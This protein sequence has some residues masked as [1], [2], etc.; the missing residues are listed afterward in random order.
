MS[1]SAH[2]FDMEFDVIPF[3]GRALLL[4]PRTA[5]DD[6]LTLPRIGQYLQDTSS[7]EDVVATTAELM[8][9]GPLGALRGE[10]ARRSG[11]YRADDVVAR[12]FRLPI[13]FDEDGDGDWKS[14]LEASGLSRS[15]YVDA[16]LQARFQVAMYGF[17]P[18]FLYM[19]G[20]SDP[21]QC[22]RKST[23]ATGCEAGSVAVGGPWFGIYGLASP[24]GWNVIGRTPVQTA[25]LPELPPTP[26][27]IG[28]VIT[29]ESIEKAE[30]DK[31]GAEDHDI[32]EFQVHD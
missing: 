9:A 6:P 2:L 20:L 5:P 31:L 1:E 30:F 27:R 14:V 26:F 8:V 4:R 7:I 17:I 12:T 23:P 25:T 3:G 16:L 22:P 11:S 10:L 21:L 18:G 32:T 13:L 29:L 15:A 28:D 19:N 24:A